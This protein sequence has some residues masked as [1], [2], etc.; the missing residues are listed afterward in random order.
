MSS[1]TATGSSG[2]NVLPT[3][4]VIRYTYAVLRIAVG[5]LLHDRTKF[6]SA[7]VGVAFSAAMVAAQ[8]G[9]YFGFLDACSGLIHRVHGDLWVMG[10]G[11]SA[12][13]YGR[14]LRAE[15][16]SL[17]ASH[18]CVVRVK[19]VMAFYASLHKSRTE[20][21]MSLIIASEGEE[22]VL[23]WNLRLG[24]PADLKDGFRISVDRSDLAR[25]ALPQA[26]LGATLVINDFPLRVAA[27]SEGIRSFTL[28]PTLFTGVS[29][30]RRLGRLPDGSAMYW[31]AT[32]RDP[33][34]V[35]DVERWVAADPDL[36]AR[37][38]AEFQNDTE[39][40]WI[41]GSG[42]G[43]VLGFST[44]LCL[45]VGG[46]I[47]SETLY[48]LARSHAKELAV[49]RA[50]GSSPA[51][52]AR[53]VLWQASIVALVGGALGMGT[54]VPLA[55]AAA[56]LGLNIVLTGSVFLVASGVIV[57]LV[58]LSSIASIW[59]TVRVEPSVVFQT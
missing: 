36:Q 52:L 59:A 8:I 46:V 48:S 22:D 9:L 39:K 15:T 30:A 50:M 32:L 45:I 29:T 21:I 7:T 40:Y 23:P 54:A 3:R 51:A 49:L 25:L 11:V 10:R 55:S 35:P 42:A 26:P 44:L 20:H 4:P 24:L 34:C 14:P 19:A 17:L 13:D 6:G 37:S 16:R 27:V 43:L 38:S 47:V 57:M 58:L 56:K 53:F 31:V 18:P 28:S 1:S 33:G 41:S 5:S 2:P 12:L